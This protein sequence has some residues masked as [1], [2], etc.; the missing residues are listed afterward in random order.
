M[1]NSINESTQTQASES[2]HGQ[3]DTSKQVIIPRQSCIY[4][5]IDLSDTKPSLVKSNL[6]IQ[7][8]RISPFP[9]FETYVITRNQH[10]MFWLWEKNGTNSDSRAS[11]IK[12]LPESLFYGDINADKTELVALK[13]GY[14]ARFWQSGLLKG[15]QFWPGKPTLTQ[16]NQFLRHHSIKASE[17]LPEVVGGHLRTSPWHKPSQLENAVETVKTINVPLVLSILFLTFL[18]FQLASI[19]RISSTL[20]EI[21]NAH[22]QA[23]TDASDIVTAR[24][25]ALLH[26]GII[27]QIHNTTRWPSQIELMAISTQILKDLDATLLSWR[28]DEGELVIMIR[29]NNKDSKAFVSSFENSGLFESVRLDTQA[30]QNNFSLQMQLKPRTNNADTAGGAS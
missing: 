2:A 17:S 29:T 26:K 14:E 23:I 9:M 3:A 20:S 10:A 1:D 21:E 13:D 19:F 25:N 27:E 18:A 6:N 30:N 8:N 24:N 11:S 7:L 5:C 15:S 4:G 28:F 16:W 22:E 12:Y